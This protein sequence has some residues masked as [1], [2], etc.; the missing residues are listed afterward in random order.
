MTYSLRP[1][2]E[3]Q[4]RVIINLHQQYEV[5]MQAEKDLIKLPYGMRWKMSAGCDFLTPP[6][7]G[8]FPFDNRLRSPSGPRLYFKSLLCLSQVN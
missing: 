5:W 2:S 6:E 7:G 1:F 3:E 4:N 8:C